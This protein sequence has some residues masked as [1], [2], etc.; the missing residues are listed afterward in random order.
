MLSGLVPVPRLTTVC[1]HGYGVAV[2]P[3]ARLLVTSNCDD[4]TL[5]VFA[6]PTLP[7]PDGSEC[8]D[9]FCVNSTSRVRGGGGGAELDAPPPL[10]SPCEPGSVSG[11]PRLGTL[12]GPDSPPPLRFK[13]VD[14]SASG[15]LAFTTSTTHQPPLLLVTDA[16]HNAVHVVD[17]INRQHVGYV[18]APGTLPGPRGVAVTRHGGDAGAA[19]ESTQSTQSSAASPA[20]CSSMVAVSSWAMWDSG[21]HLVHLFRGGG[22]T[23]SHLRVCGAGFGAPGSAMGQLHRPYGVRFSPDGSQLAI[24]DM[25]NCRVVMHSVHPRRCSSSSSSSGAGDGAAICGCS[26]S[27]VRIVS[28][29]CVWPYDV[30]VV[31]WEDL[32]CQWLVADLGR[33]TMDCFAGTSPCSASAS[34]SSCDSRAV[35]WAGVGTMGAQGRGIGQFKFPAALALVPDL[36]LV[37]RE[38]GNGGRVQV[39][40]T[41][42]A[43]AMASMSRH[44]LAW[45]AAAARVV[46]HVT[47]VKT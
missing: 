36:G 33:H 35:T 7:W 14:G 39:F 18:A 45:M 44:R 10:P 8:S 11:L 26:W 47:L 3:I 24:A 22:T 17:V 15:Y 34:G 6:L 4:N 19:L 21:D 28:A 46:A 13:F 30:E 29:A 1:G 16:G 5:A 23:W 32:E 31:K 40:A 37:V 25:G 43:I 2:S 38:A 20:S 42:D 27:L 12:G 41:P 9:R